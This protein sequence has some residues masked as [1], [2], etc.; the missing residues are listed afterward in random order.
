[1]PELFL[2]ELDKRETEMKKGGQGTLAFDL[3]FV[4]CTSKAVSCVGIVQGVYH[5]VRILPFSTCANHGGGMDI[6]E[7]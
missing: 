3:V 2:R 6:R 7:W 4:T 1:M 5:G